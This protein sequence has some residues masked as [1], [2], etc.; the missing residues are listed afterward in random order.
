MIPQQAFLWDNPEVQYNAENRSWFDHWRAQGAEGEPLDLFLNIKDYSPRSRYEVPEFEAIGLNDV[1][2][3]ICDGKL[4][5]S[6]KPVV[7]LHDQGDPESRDYSGVM[8]VRRFHE[9]HQMKV[10]T[11]Y[12]EN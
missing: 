6:P 2:K 4:P 10:W 9:V 5:E 12:P 1:L 8:S 3:R 11:I 7:W